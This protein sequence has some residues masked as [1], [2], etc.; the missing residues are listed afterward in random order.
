MEQI[1]SQRDWARHILGAEWFDRSG[2]AGNEG[3]KVDKKKAS[4]IYNRLIQHEN[5]KVQDLH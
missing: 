1:S 2:V 5:K 3:E 4:Q